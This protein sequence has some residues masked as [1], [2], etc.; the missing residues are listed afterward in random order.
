MRLEINFSLE[1]FLNYR[2][3][4]GVLLQTAMSSICKQSQSL[5]RRY[6][7]CDTKACL[8]GH[9]YISSSKALCFNLFGNTFI[10]CIISFTLE[11]AFSE[12]QETK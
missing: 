5:W 7:R 12:I 10:W 1:Y 11:V 2:V 9:T 3:H 4:F 8:Q 6:F